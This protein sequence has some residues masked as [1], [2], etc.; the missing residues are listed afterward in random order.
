MKPLD[1]GPKSPKRE[2]SQSPFHT[3]LGFSQIS[4]Q[5]Q[6]A[7][8]SIA[9]PAL[10]LMPTHAVV[11]VEYNP[12]GSQSALSGC[13][14]QGCLTPAGLI[15]S[16]HRFSKIRL[17]KSLIQNLISMPSAPTCSNPINPSGACESACPVSSWPGNVLDKPHPQH[18][19]PWLWIHAVLI[20]SLNKQRRGTC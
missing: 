18:Q 6:N 9:L 11:S 20:H 17:L 2:L 4:L 12:L 14:A 16:L 3:M 15:R 5:W 19:F 13:L 10:K 7:D 1:V 8:Q